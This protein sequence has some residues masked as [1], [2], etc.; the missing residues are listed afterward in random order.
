MFFKSEYGI[1]ALQKYT[2]RGN[3]GKQLKTE[4]NFFLAFTFQE[5]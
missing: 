5:D 2:L 4:N 1:Y 3:L